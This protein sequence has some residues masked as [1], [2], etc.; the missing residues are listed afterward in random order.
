MNEFYVPNF[1]QKG[2][3]S[4]ELNLVAT[5]ANV[6]S[7]EMQHFQKGLLNWPKNMMDINFN[8]A[9]ISHNFN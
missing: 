1:F 4:L 6:G 5:L 3:G 8:V 7:I 9:L 2:S